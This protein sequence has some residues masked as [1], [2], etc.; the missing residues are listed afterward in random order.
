MNHRHPE[1]SER[2]ASRPAPPRTSRFLQIPAAIGIAAAAARALLATASAGL[3]QP[4]C[5][6]YGQAMDGY[7]FPYSTNATVVLLH[8]TNE[9]AS[10]SIRGSLSAGVNFALYVHLD[11]GTGARS[12]S[13][14]ALRSGDLASVVVRTPAGQRTI[15]EQQAV[16]PVGEPGELIMI[17]VTASGDADGDALPDAWEEELILWSGGALTNLSDVNPEDD[18]DGDGQINRDEYRAGTF[19]FLG[20]DLLLAEDHG[21]TANGRFRIGFLS[22]RGKLYGVRYVTDLRHTL[23]NPSPIAVSETADFQ[24]RPTEG[25]G[26][27]MSLYVPGTIDHAYFRPTVETLDSYH[28]SAAAFVTSLVAMDI[29]GDKAGGDATLSYE[30][31]MRLEGEPFGGSSQLSGATGD[32]TRVWELSGM[33]A[34][35]RGLP[36][37][38]HH[39]LWS[40][41]MV[42]DRGLTGFSGFNLKSAARSGFEAAEVIRVGL[43]GSPESSE[44][45]GVSV[46]T[47]GG[48]TYA[49]LDCG[50]IDGRGDVLT[51]QLWWEE[52]GD[53]T[54]TVANADEGTM[55][56]FEGRLATSAITMLAVGLFGAPS[57]TLHFNDLRFQTAPELILESSEGNML[58][59]WLAG[60]PGVRLQSTESVVPQGEWTAVDAPVVT[61]NG[62]NSVTLPASSA[63]RFFRLGK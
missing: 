9:I 7:G 13:P 10:H 58:L 56:R 40:I 60:F 53:F 27:W 4:M 46:S 47:D 31:W 3:P 15:M 25:T 44:I 42:H 21:A 18:F 14:R 6:Y 48:K 55:S 30:P 49:F 45:K 16:P 34:V 20:E 22:V 17:N 24:T 50:W 2:F 37:I 19:P 12:Y 1:G 33:Q 26:G 29:A 41:R 28:L 11:D 35:G 62:L 59:S 63:P 52:S 23:W 38:A 8:G 39:G 5:V 43:L 36:G 32:G 54:L 51:Y 57:E 61:A